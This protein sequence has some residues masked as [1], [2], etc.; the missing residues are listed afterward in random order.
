MKFFP[1]PAPLR[2]YRPAKFRPHDSVLA[3]V[4]IL[5]FF[6]RAYVNG[7]SCV[8]EL[9][10]NTCEG[11]EETFGAH[12]SKTI[13]VIACRCDNT[14]LNHLYILS[15]FFAAMLRIVCSM[16][17]FVLSFNLS[18]A[19]WRYSVIG[20]IPNVGLALSSSLSMSVAR[21]ACVCVSDGCQC[22]C[23]ESKFAVVALLV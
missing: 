10:N 3:F 17:L 9:E 16:F 23:D 4:C 6:H 15:T 21:Y 5:F 18:A 22:I 20:T 2:S 7:C 1:R 11:I 12:T 13:F 14:H 19:L 8:G